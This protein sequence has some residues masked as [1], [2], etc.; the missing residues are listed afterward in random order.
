M[1]RVFTEQ[2]AMTI[3]MFSCMVLGIFL[4]LFLGIL[5]AHM[6]KE[7][8]NMAS[9]DNKLLK[10]CKTKFSNCYELKRN[11]TRH[12]TDSAFVHAYYKICLSR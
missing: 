1:I 10:Q 3:C 5:Y 9:T 6:I 7:A 8:D 4:K 12:F 2:A 11:R